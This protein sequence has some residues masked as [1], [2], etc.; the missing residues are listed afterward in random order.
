MRAH[1]PAAPMNRRSL[2]KM[3]GM[4]AGSAVM[5]EA[6]SQLGHAGESGYSGPIRLEG[7][8]KGTSVLILGAA[9]MRRG[10]AS[11]SWARVWRA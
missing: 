11:S 6:M 9:A 4:I 8:P 3:I 10:P 1:E 2:F 7:D 5:Y